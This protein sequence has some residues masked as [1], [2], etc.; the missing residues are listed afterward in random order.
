[1]GGKQPGSLSPALHRKGG[2]RPRSQALWGDT[3]SPNC[4]LPGEPSPYMTLGIGPCLSLVA[5]AGSRSKANIYPMVIQIRLATPPPTFL[6]YKFPDLTTLGL[7]VLVC[8]GGIQG[9]LG[10]E[11]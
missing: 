5:S 4:D 1:M 8:G 2:L 9:G 7:G 6:E 10:E 11:S 3:G